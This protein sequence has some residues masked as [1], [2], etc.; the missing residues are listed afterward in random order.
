[1]PILPEHQLPSK[2]DFFNSIGHSQQVE[3]PRSTR[4]KWHPRGLDGTGSSCESGH[5]EP[6]SCDSLAG[7]YM[8]A[9][10][11]VVKGQERRYLLPSGSGC[12]RCALPGDV[13]KSIP[14]IVRLGRFHH[15]VRLPGSNVFVRPSPA[16]NWVPE[17]S[18]DVTSPSRS[19]AADL[20]HF[21]RLGR[22]AV[23]WAGSRTIPLTMPP[24][25]VPGR[26]CRQ[27][28]RGVP[29][30]A[31]GDGGV[32]PRSLASSGNGPRATQGHRPWRP[33]QP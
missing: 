33:S 24:L 29:L 22:G 30:A 27:P 2:T 3:A 1:L 32:W 21:A 18:S 15:E 28:R 20:R 10:R 17:D 19:S 11:S 5:A 25:Y 8:I 16:T 9:L 12:R 4:M 13:L 31:L 14:A 23:S 26:L 7:P 6:T